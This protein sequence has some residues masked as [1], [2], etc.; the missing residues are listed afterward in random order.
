MN[1]EVSSSSIIAAVLGLIGCLN[2]R[3]IPPSSLYSKGRLVF[4]VVAVLR[5][6]RYL[7]LSRIFPTHFSPDIG[8]VSARSSLIIAWIS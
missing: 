2:L 8:V 5:P 4:V 7:R 1:A 3:L 6:M